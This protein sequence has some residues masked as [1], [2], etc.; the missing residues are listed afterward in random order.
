M[1]I[2]TLASLVLVTAAAAG[3]PQL[4]PEVQRDQLLLRAERLIEADDP[5]AALE[6]LGE[7]LALQAEHGIELPP[8]YHFRRAQAAFDAARLET[9][10]EAV[11]RYLTDSG[12]EGEF[13]GNAL[14]LLEDVEWILERRD[15]PAC[16]GQPEGAECWMEVANQPGC[17]VWNE[18]FQPEATATWTGECSSGLVTGPGKLTWEWPPENHQEHDG[19][20]RLGRSHGH[21]VIGFENGQIEKGPFVDGKRNGQWVLDY[22]N[23]TTAKGPFAND[24]RNGPWVLTFADG[25]VEEGRFVDG[26][27]IGPWVIRRPDGQIDEGPFVAGERAGHW[28]L[29]L[30]DGGIHEGPYMDGKQTGHWIL[31]FGDGQIESGPMADGK[32]H[33]PWVIIWPDGDTDRGSFVA[34]MRQGRWVRESPPPD[35]RTCYI[36]YVADEPDGEWDCRSRDGRN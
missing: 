7:V 9:A 32:R 2:N 23:G 25:Q 5:E 14:E 18:H 17:H 24:E 36:Q 1:A 26:E 15:A 21:A 20:F 35:A 3:G 10:K 28:L 22:P 6:A 11:T 30:P 27:R 34:D 31:T 29:K 8:K 19:T 13:Y 16:A 4:P 33:G 12:P